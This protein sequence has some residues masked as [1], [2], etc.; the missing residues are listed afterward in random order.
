MVTGATDGLG[1]AI[2]FELA[3]RG[4][5]VII[6][7]RSDERGERTIAE[8][9][10]ELPEAR[11]EFYR[12]DLSR[13]SEVRDLAARVG[14]AHSRLD[15]LVNNAGIYLDERRLS[16]D[17]NELVLQVN[18]LSHVLLT[19]LLLPQLKAAAPSR[20]VNVASAGQAP[21]DF[22]DLHLEH[23]YSGGISYQR[24]KLAQIMFTIDLA[25]SL[26]DENVTVNALHPATFMPTKMV[27]GRFPPSSR[28][29]DGVAATL[30]LIAAPD[31][32]GLSGRYFNM[33]REHRAISQAYDAA[34]RRRLAELTEA[35]ISP[36]AT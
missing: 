22:D 17:G 15:A 9:R 16:H 8:I 30:R 10:A 24:S 31:L 35:L 36:S 26:R 18:Y 21:I 23:G 2:A 25:E 27:V 32:E 5:W 13:L 20:V 1:K 29:E 33:Q 19:K 28:I 34:A 7:G 12:A 4:S 11:L 6:H 3:R 14:A